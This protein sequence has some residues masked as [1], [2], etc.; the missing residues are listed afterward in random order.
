MS[1]VV[2]LARTTLSASVLA[3]CLLTFGWPFAVSTDP[4]HPVFKGA[5]IATL[6]AFLLSLAALLA[7]KLRRT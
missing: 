2:A 1:A 5:A 7:C 4:S 3:M 6:L